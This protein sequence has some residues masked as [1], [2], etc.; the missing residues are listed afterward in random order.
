MYKKIGKNG[1]LALG[2]F[3][4]VLV[5]SGCSGKENA[6]KNVSLLP[7]QETTQ[8]AEQVISTQEQVEKNIEQEAKIPIVEI[9]KETKTEK[10]PFQTIKKDDDTLE[11][12]KTKTIQSGVDGTR[13]FLYE[14]TYADEIETKRELISEEIKKE[15]VDK[16]VASG[17]KKK[18]APASSLSLAVS[19]GEDYYENVDGNCVHRPSSETAGASA[20]CKDGT[21]SYSQH[22]SGTCSGHGGVAEWL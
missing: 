9:K 18:I 5:F 10:I 6:E 21:Y 20:K 11:I 4:I 15:A 22:R 13:E 12:G 2:L 3:L 8:Q 7:T 19:C 17:T 14:V 16:I 1:L